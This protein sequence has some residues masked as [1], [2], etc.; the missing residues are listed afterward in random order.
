MTYNRKATE[1]NRTLDPSLTKRLLCR[2]SYGGEWI[3]N[4]WANYT[5]PGVIGK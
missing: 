2:L 4:Y 3:F 1:G 5:K